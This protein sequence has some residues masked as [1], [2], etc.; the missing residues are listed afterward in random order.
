MKTHE[1]LCKFIEIGSRAFIL[2]VLIVTVPLVIVCF[3]K[4]FTSNYSPDSFQL[5]FPSTYVNILMEIIINLF[6]T[7]SN[8][9]GFLLIGKHQLVLP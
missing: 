2:L 1:K 9:L 3:S 7:Y 4:Y 6:E 8:I 5:L